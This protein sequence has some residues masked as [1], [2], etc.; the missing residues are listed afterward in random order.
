MSGST[1]ATPVSSNE[2]RGR[3]NGLARTAL[4]SGIVAAVLTA[5]SAV[6]TF[7]L[8][9][10]AT[11]FNGPLALMGF[12]GPFAAVLGVV[13]GALGLKSSERRQAVIGLVLSA[14]SGVAWILILTMAPWP[15]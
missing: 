1:L 4:V 13:C 9:L 3:G 15:E 12:L 14:V 6:L 10:E 2:V 7:T 5:L 8:W 11:P